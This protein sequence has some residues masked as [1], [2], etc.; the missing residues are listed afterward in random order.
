MENQGE[1]RIRE[2]ED[3]DRFRPF[4]QRPWAFLLE[5][6]RLSQ[7]KS[8]I[9]GHVT[10][11]IEPKMEHYSS[12]TMRNHGIMVVNVEK[13][14]K[15]RFLRFQ[16]SD[17]F[18]LTCYRFLIHKFWHFLTFWNFLKLWHLWNFDN[19]RNSDIFWNS[20]ISWDSVIFWHSG[21]FSNS[22]IFKVDSLNF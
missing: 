2:L 19:F 13:C 22:D 8:N 10:G 3:S 21:I 11:K 15:Y 12:G 4:Y 1:G 6:W 7:G 20:D 9:E 17:I 14:Q 18:V 5:L 16:F